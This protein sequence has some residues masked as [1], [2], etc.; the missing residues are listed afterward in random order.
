MKFEITDVFKRSVTLEVDTGCIYHADH[1]YEVWL[2]GRPVMQARRNVITLT[3]LTPDTEYVVGV[4]AAG[5]EA[6]DTQ[7]FRTQAE[8]FLLNVRRFGAAGDG[9]KDDTPA[10]QA[11]IA[12]CP[13]GGTVVLPKGE[14][15][16][17]PLF[18]KSHMTLWLD[19]GAVLKG[20]ADRAS[21]PVLPGMT[22]GTG[23]GEY[24]LGTWEGNPLDC[25]ASLVTGID[26][27][28]TD[29]VGPGRIDGG[30]DEGDW[31]EE[32][33]KR[34]VAWR[35]NTIFLCRCRHV[36]LQ[37]LT[38]GNSP[39]WTI[40]PYYCEDLRVLDLTIVNPYDSPNTDG[41]D[42][43]SCRDVLLLGSRIC[44]GDDCVAIKSGK[45]YMAVSHAMRTER[46][47]IRSCRFREGHGAV[48]IGS[49]AAC[50][51]DD[52]RVSGCLFE[53]TDRGIRLKTRRG[54]GEMSRLDHL[55]F[56]DIRM[57]GVALPAT[58]NMFYYCDPDGHSPYVQDTGYHEPDEMTP[59]IGSLTIRRTQCTGA[60]P[61]GVCVCA[62]PE[63]PVE[64]ITL[65]DVGVT[66]QPAGERRPGVPIMMDGFPEMDGRSFYFNQVKKLKLRNVRISGA[67]DQEPELTGIGE[68]E[69]EGLEY[70]AGGSGL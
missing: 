34:R 31:W 22:E 6:A 11:A 37:N 24:N 12:A 8:T 57:D 25:F 45:Y 52:V 67:A 53:G 56:E 60:G 35:P 15:R 4:R 28:D 19:E 39:S 61:C 2:D 30:A 1:P 62:L 47:R 43:E 23:A 49:E 70:Q 66:F 33:K 26:I 16:S 44:V 36:R 69:I 38:V 65:E 3:G 14:Y 64:E 46:I 29:L 68:Q 10:I 7:T 63:S 48:T 59:Q 55:L 9:A 27:E 21:Y 17:G 42:P 13:E 51:V 54:R 50:G 20:L 32:P 5:E 41:F 58:V 18:L 40:H